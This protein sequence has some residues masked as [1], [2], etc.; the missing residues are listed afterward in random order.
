MKT[1]RISWRKAVAT[2]VSV[3]AVVALVTGAVA[4][5]E[6]V[7]KKTTDSS[8]FEKQLTEVDLMMQTAQQLIDAGQWE[9]AVNQ[10][11][12]V[13]ETD[14]TRMDGWTE[15]A[16]CYKALKRYD[17]A[18]A[19]YNSAHNL[20]PKNLDL[21]SN[22]GYAQLNAGQLDQALATYNQ[23]LA[24][25]PLSYD[26]N[27]H[28]GFVF[29]KQGDPEKAMGYY[30]KALEGNANDVQTMGSLAE[31][32]ANNGREKDATAMYE[33]AIA[34]A[35]PAQKN[36][37]RAKLGS[38]LIASKNFEKAAEVY[39]ALVADNPDSAPYRFNYGISLLQLNKNKEAADQLAK[40]V[41]LKPDYAPA[42]QQLAAAYNE[43]G[44]YSQAIAVAKKGLALTDK[45]AGLYCAW[46]RSLEKQQLYDEAIDIF[47]KAVN[48]PQYGDYAKK[49]IQRQM[50]LK[51]RAKMIREQQ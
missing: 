18:A 25:D 29:D 50:D 4:A 23:M 21:L 39:G 24:I 5:Q 16:R 2:A 17:M 33:R 36:T 8:G 11:K 34:A 42:Y 19:A 43:T 38:S 28:L 14:S 22:L 10:L 31:L 20:D 40:V 41:E 6:K 51:K 46:G 37:L 3:V 45:K 35:E 30:E 9:E 7:I 13:T 27:V 26:A 48:D 12:R 15:L 1:Y 32:Y 49:Q 47:Q 44:R